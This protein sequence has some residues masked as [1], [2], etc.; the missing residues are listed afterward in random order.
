MRTP[1]R[2]QP[3]MP[4][5]IL[6]MALTLLQIFPVLR[7]LFMP[8]LFL[9]S[10]ISLW[11]SEGAAYLLAIGLTLIIGH[12]TRLK[13]RLPTKVPGSNL[14]LAGIALHIVNKAISITMLG[15]FGLFGKHLTA[16]HGAAACMQGLAILGEALL[17]YGMA[18]VL[19]AAMPRLPA[20]ASQGA[21][22]H[23]LPLAILGIGLLLAQSWPSARYLLLGPAAIRSMALQHGAWVGTSQ[24]YIGAMTF[25]VSFTRITKLGERLPPVMP[26]RIALTIGAVLTFLSW[27]IMIGAEALHPPG[28]GM[29]FTLVAAGLAM[30]LGFVAKI[31]LITGLTQ[32]FLAALPSY[33]PTH[34]K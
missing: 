7:A 28:T 27:A 9:S 30:L 26:G 17:L 21:S 18:Q 6:G 19:L 13:S 32:V 29:G 34:A 25:A 2:V 22:R 15:R 31:P 10:G 5:I 16:L 11:I 33:R 24:L 4:T 1:P 12:V 14:L 23:N 8:S 3:K 20:K